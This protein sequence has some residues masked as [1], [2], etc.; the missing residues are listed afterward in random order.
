ME[1]IRDDSKTVVVL[2]NDAERKV[3]GQDIITRREVLKIRGETE[4]VLTEKMHDELLVA[5]SLQ[6]DKSKSD[7]ERLKEIAN[8]LHKT[9]KFPKFE[10]S[11]RGKREY[12]IRITSRSIRSWEKSDQKFEFLNYFA[13][14]VIPY[15]VSIGTRVMSVENQYGAI[16]EKFVKRAEAKGFFY[17]TMPGRVTTKLSKP[18]MLHD[19]KAFNQVKNFVFDLYEIFKEDW[20]IMMPMLDVLISGRCDNCKT[21]FER[22]E[23]RQFVNSYIQCPVCNG[24]MSEDC[25]V[26]YE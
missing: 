4:D 19:E 3:L 24:I 25:R 14:D 17:D 18:I 2:H 21:V 11:L 9:F 16:L 7:S 10:K 1:T 23:A 12:T 5:F 8:F 6:S 13:R 22:A 20:H 15:I 26:V